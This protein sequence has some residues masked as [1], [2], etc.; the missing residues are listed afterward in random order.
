MLWVSSKAFASTH[1]AKFHVRP[2][3]YRLVGGVARHH[4]SVI[5][6]IPEAQAVPL[7][8]CSTCCGVGPTKA[9]KPFCE[10]CSSFRAC[11]HNGG[12]AVV[13]RLGISWVWPDRVHAHAPLAPP[14]IRV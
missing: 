12:V 7:A 9:F 14:R 8:P 1:K 13:T 6:A 10:V 11:G 5:M 2:D 3:C 4:T